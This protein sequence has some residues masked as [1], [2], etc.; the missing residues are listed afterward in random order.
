MARIV[1]DRRGVSPDRT[2]LLVNGELLP[3]DSIAAEVANF[4]AASV[5]ESWQ[6]ARDALVLR[7][8]LRQRAAALGLDVTPQADAAGRRETDEDAGL[9]AL[10]EAEVTPVAPTEAEAVAYYAA[11]PERFRA[12]ALFEAAHILLPADPADAEA[13]TA[14]AARAATI[15]A[16]LAAQ[17]ERFAELAKEFSGCSSAAQGGALGQI[18]GG[19]TTPEFEAALR[20]LVPGA[21]SGPVA[22]RFGLHIIQL[23]QRVE[24]EVLPY[25]VVGPRIRDYLA[26]RAVHRATAAYLAQVLAEAEVV[27]AETPVESDEARQLRAFVA[28]AD[29]ER[30]LQLVGVMNRADDPAAAGRTAIAGGANGLRPA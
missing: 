4:P 3:L 12:P 22:T 5:A 16:I 6:A 1:I 18:S 28:A 24:G 15:G 20:S 19:E 21:I 26:D 14:A 17:P 8:A 11:N 23:M 10:L 9:R 30:W 29:D 2:P 7:L 27:A 25:A 13:Q